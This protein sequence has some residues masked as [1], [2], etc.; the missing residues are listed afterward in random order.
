MFIGALLPGLILSALYF[1]YILVTASM[2]PSIAPPMDQDEIVLE[3]TQMANTTLFCGL[4]AV[5]LAIG[6]FLPET[7]FLPD[8][9]W[10]LLAFLGIF[11]SAMYVGKREGNTMLGAVLKG[12]VPPIFLIVLVLGSIFAGWATPTEAAGVGAFGSMLLAWVNGT[13]TYDVLKQVCHRTG[14]TTAMIFFIFVGA[15]A[16]SHI[17]RDTYGEDLIIEFIEWLHLGPWPLL[18]MLMGTIF[19]LGFFFDFL[20]ITL[21][22]LP[23]FA[24]IIKALA[25]M[26]APHLGLEAGASQSEILFVQSQVI[27]W[28]AILVAVNLQTSFLTPPFG[29]ALFYMKGVAPSEVKMQSIYRGIIPFVI[30]QLI[31]PRHRHRV[32]A[33][34]P[35]AAQSNAELA[36]FEAPR[37]SFCDGRLGNGA[38][39]LR[40]GV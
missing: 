37:F 15:T 20:E 19:L 24:P 26:F 18:F 29:F 5:F 40:L 31:G 25:P 6:L 11:F 39:I 30:L 10:T 9:N 34:R 7:G 8:V 22:I 21:I 13:L 32:P 33:A 38:A 35:M 23:V 3:P 16:F 17:F 1:T 14:L 2:N 4:T 36:R 27:Y 12:F 28:F